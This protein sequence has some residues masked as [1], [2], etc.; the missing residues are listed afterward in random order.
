LSKQ[1][2]K[3]EHDYIEEINHPKHYT[4][5]KHEPIDVI[6]EWGLNFN[7]G[8]V[9]KYIARADRKENKLQDLKKAQWYLNR[10]IVAQEGK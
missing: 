10:E 8:N 2:F 7:L 1:I 3:L 4:T 5:G 9:I 6:E